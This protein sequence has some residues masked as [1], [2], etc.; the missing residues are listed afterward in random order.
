MIYKGQP[1]LRLSFIEFRYPSLDRAHQL[2]DLSNGNFSQCVNKQVFKYCPLGVYL[3]R[4]CHEL[5]G[6]QRSLSESELNISP[7]NFSGDIIR[8]VKLVTT[9]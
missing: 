2:V 9:K 6:K 7:R 4:V 5:K 1:I 3:I 8:G